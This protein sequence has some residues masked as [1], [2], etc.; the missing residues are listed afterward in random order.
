M[1]PIDYEKLVNQILDKSLDLDKLTEMVAEEQKRRKEQEKDE[2]RRAEVEKCKTALVDAVYDWVW[3]TNFEE[4][5]KPPVGSL[6]EYMLKERIKNIFEMLLEDPEIKDTFSNLNGTKEEEED[7][8]REPHTLDINDL[9]IDPIEA[10][11]KKKE[12]LREP[13]HDPEVLWSNVSDK[14]PIREWLNY[15][16]K[17]GYWF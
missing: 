15:K 8:R 6:G 4:E 12:E 9:N 7:V 10:L 1:T 14:S 5:K 2:K 13:E 17:G 16:N 3:L 11:R